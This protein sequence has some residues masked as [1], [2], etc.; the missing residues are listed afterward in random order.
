MVTDVAAAEEQNKLLKRMW[1]PLRRKELEDGN[2][3]NA[4]T[5][6][7]KETDKIHKIQ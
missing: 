1:R 2:K 3:R 4:K 7:K 6:Q 5:K